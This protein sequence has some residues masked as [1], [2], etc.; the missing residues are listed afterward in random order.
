[1]KKK[2]IATTVAASL[3][4]ASFAGLPLSQKGLFEKIGFSSTAHAATLDDVAGKIQ[5]LKSFLWEEG[6]LASIET[7]NTALK[8]LTD[9]SLIQP[10]IQDI[11]T[12]TYPIDAE[13]VL[14]LFTELTPFFDT[15]S[16][17][18]KEYLNKPFVRGI[19]HQL[20]AASGVDLKE[21]EV[22]T[23]DVINYASKF[24]SE[25]FKQLE[26]AGL[27]SL[28]KLALNDRDELKKLIKQAADVVMSDTTNSFNQILQGL[29][30]T[31][32]DIAETSVNFVTA[33]DPDHKATYNLGV[34][35]LRYKINQTYK[36]IENS[37]SSGTYKAQ[38]NIA[39]IKF[40]AALLKVSFEPANGN[41][42]IS[43]DGATGTISASSSSAGS[44]IGGQ[45]TGRINLPGNA[46]HDKLIIKQS[47]TLSK[48]EDKP[49]SGGGGGGGGFSSTTDPAVDAVSKEL[50]N[51]AAEI[52]KLE[53]TAKQ[54]YLDKLV[55][56]ASEALA[57]AATLD[58]ANKM[59]VTDG[60]A[61]LKIDAADLAKQ[62]QNVLD[63]AK[64]LGDKLDKLGVKTDLAAKLELKLNLGTVN[65]AS[66]A[67]PLP[68]AVL[69]AAQTGKIDSIAIQ[70]NG[71]GVALDPDAFK[72]DTNLAIQTK[73]ASAAKEATDL[74]VASKVYEFT[75]TVDGKNVSTFSEPIVLSLPVGD[76]SKFDAEKLTLAKII[77][78]KLEFYG[79]KY[80]AGS[81]QLSQQRSSFSSYTVVEN[82]VKFDD[83]AS[84]QAWAGRQI[85]VA[86]AKGIVEGR[87][88]KQFVPNETVT[89]AEFAKMIVNTFGL[90]APNAS[91]SFDDVDA[92]DWFQP[93][94]ASA[95]KHGLVNGRSEG[96]F[97]PNGKITRAEMATIAARALTSVKELAAVKDTD[98]AL[99]G[100]VDS[101]DINDSLKAGVALSASAGIVVGE[102][103]DKFN[104][105]DNSTRAQAA[106]VIYRLLNK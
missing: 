101:A 72:G 65:A 16:T 67:V 49:S 98:A 4:V 69:S 25:V 95:V 82:N 54:E 21:G 74:P 10:L 102:E 5:T 88:D 6:E 34:A 94:V 15:N 37:S 68:K 77:G 30:I 106:V 66:I 9:T 55:E 17:N 47:I 59:T 87:A 79:G 61:E 85:E 63:Q 7:A 60:K 50:D 11:D 99:K 52:A 71:V 26:S 103:G 33:A 53:G 20:E 86:A 64:L 13:G 28:G 84:V 3:T 12:T 31:S 62:I 35:A 38:F 92:S 29:S 44:S 78:D 43:Y 32:T 18:M 100:F 22:T 104:P 90:Q 76:V 8:G 105:N 41:V 24:Q 89:R 81:K 19:L 83:T 93:Y 75:I 57:K 51:A 56:K 1:M 91:E 2:I 27:E 36:V 45:V 80:D 97:E 70:V 42:S 39:G 23:D 96:K 48:D 46:L 14:D 58:L 73:D 40:P